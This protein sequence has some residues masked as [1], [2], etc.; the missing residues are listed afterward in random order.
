MPICFLSSR[1]FQCKR[2]PFQADRAA[3]VQEHFLQH[4]KPSEV[5]F[6]CRTCNFRARSEGLALAHRRHVHG[7]PRDEKIMVG[8]YGTFERMPLEEM[9]SDIVLPR[10]GTNR[11]RP[12]PATVSTTS[13]AEEVQCDR[14]VASKK[15]K[16][17]TETMTKSSTTRDPSNQIDP[18]TAVSHIQ[19]GVSEKLPTMGR[20]PKKTPCTDDD[21]ME[22]ESLDL[23]NRIIQGADASE[24]VR[25]RPL[26]PPVPE[27]KTKKLVREALHQADTAAQA[28]VDARTLLKGQDK[29]MR[30]IHRTLHAL[31]VES[32]TMNT[33]LARV[34]ELRERELVLLERLA[35]NQD[36]VAKAKA[37]LME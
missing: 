31:L 19:I 11:K 25:S 5:P 17:K 14:N 1:M 22:P 20:I 16:T 4:L 9:L 3:A 15:K 32:K 10:G 24:T 34:H 6:G 21:I 28:S 23:A 26:E 12:C 2:C 7:V 8:C 37:A 29:T 35:T 18:P 13:T 33:N 30:G 27:T 36:R